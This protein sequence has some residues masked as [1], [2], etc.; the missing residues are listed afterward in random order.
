MNIRIFLISLANLLKLIKF[1]AYASNNKTRKSH[2][3]DESLSE[4]IANE[5]R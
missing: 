4:L 3:F 2:Q 1:T 5:R